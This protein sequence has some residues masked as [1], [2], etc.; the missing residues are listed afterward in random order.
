MAVLLALKFE[1][2]PVGLLFNLFRLEAGA[3]ADA[4]D[5]CGAVLVTM[6]LPPASILQRR[7]WCQ[8]VERGAAVE[9]CG[10][11]CCRYVLDVERGIA[12]RHG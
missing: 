1:R 12:A 7:N 6:L 8:H 11:I 3:L 2:R 9:P 4:P 5:R 10:W